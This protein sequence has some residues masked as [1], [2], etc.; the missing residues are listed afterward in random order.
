MVAV[1]AG[2]DHVGAAL[3]D[4]VGHQVL[5]AVDAGELAQ[6]ERDRRP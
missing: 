4:V 3:L 6:I 5:E 1:I 2:D